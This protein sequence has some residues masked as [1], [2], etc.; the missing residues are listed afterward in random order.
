MKYYNYNHFVINIVLNSETNGA[1]SEED[2][3]K[4]LA[5]RTGTVDVIITKTDSTKETV[6]M[7]SFGKSSQGYNVTTSPFY[8]IF[9]IKVNGAYYIN[10][11]TRNNSVQL[12]WTP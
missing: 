9:G 1:I 8:R 3:K 10:I 2:C 5:A 7:A 6:T 4:L 12:S 11:N